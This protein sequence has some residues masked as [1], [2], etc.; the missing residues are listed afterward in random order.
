MVQLGIGG[1]DGAFNVRA[2]REY[3]ETFGR[4]VEQ[5]SSAGELYDRVVAAYPRRLGK[6]VLWLGCQ[7]QFPSSA[8]QQ[9]RAG[10]GKQ[11]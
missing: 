6:L 8:G 7:A 2:S 11:T 3:V 4:L 5:S 1:V 9:D 10:S